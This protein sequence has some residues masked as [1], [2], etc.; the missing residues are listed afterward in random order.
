MR[1]YPGLLIGFFLLSITGWETNFENAKKQAEQEHKLILLNFSGSDWCGPC[2]R[3]H[4]EIFESSSFQNFAENKLVLVNA[5]FPRLKKNQLSKDQQKKND[6]LAD[7]YNSEGIFPFTVLLNADGTEIKTW[8][9]LPNA[10]AE[11]Y[12]AVLKDLVNARK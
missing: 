6:K 1:F 4:D 11:Q 12:T 8:E 10:T 3:M 5:D 9:G 7:K 2:I